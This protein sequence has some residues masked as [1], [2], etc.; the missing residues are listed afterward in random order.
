[1]KPFR[2]RNHTTIGIVGFAAIGAMMLAAFRADQLPLI[3][4]G[5][6]Y[7]AEMAEVGA[8]QSGDEVRVAGVPVGEVKAIALDGDRVKVRFQLDKGAELGS[9]TSAQIKVRTLLGAEYLALTPQGEGDLEAGATIPLE[10]TIAPYNVVEA[11]SEL[12]ET[13]DRLDVQQ[14]STALSTL[15]DVAQRTPEE[16]R[17]ALRGVSAVSRNLAARD[18]QI[19]SLLGNLRTVT[20]VVSSRNEELQTLFEDSDV[21]FQAVSAR[22]DEIHRLLV[23]TQ[24]I[25]TELRGLVKDTRADLKPAL[26][27]LGK[28]TTMLRKHEASLDEALRVMAPFDTVFANAL[29]SGPWFDSYIAGLPPNLGLAQQLKEALGVTK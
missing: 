3:G 29:G 13:T 21:L 28:V 22:R 8:L 1:M 9:K 4:G 10:R 23:S 6:T 18:E 2:E 15:S 27:Q 12:S 14:I 20:T 25:S 19:Q 7:Y 11:F 5:D 26:T 16:F 24:R 17:G